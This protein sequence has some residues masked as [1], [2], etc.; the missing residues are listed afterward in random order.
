MN[1]ASRRRTPTASKIALAMAAA[2]GALDGSPPPR[3]G[4][5][6]RLIKT[7]SISGTVGKSDDRVSAPIERLDAAAVELDFFHERATDALND[8]S[9]D[10]VFQTVGIDDQSAVMG[11]NEAFDRHFACGLVDFHFRDRAADRLGAIGNRHA[12]AGCLRV[13]RRS[14]G[15]GSFLPLGLLHDRGQGVSAALVRAEV[16]HAKLHRIDALIGGDLID[17]RFAGETARDVA[18]RAQVCRCA[19]ESRRLVPTG[20][21]ARRIFDFRMHTFHRRLGCRWNCRRPWASCRSAAK[22]AGAEPRP[23]AAVR[24]SPSIGKVPGNDLALAVDAGAD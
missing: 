11:Q 2:I 10:L 19:A 23:E 22:R 6:G 13:A 24:G 15:R 12:A 17:E 7:I 1:G 16:T 14:G 18:G 20:S 5:S 4:I 9:F 8:V 3:A 21:T